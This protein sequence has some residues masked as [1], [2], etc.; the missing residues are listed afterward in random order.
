MIPFGPQLIGQ[1]EKALTAV[2]RKIL[3]PHSL[4]EAQWVTLRLAAQLEPER[5]L[6]EVIRDNNLPDTD[7]L[8]AGLIQR[9]FIVGDHPTDAGREIIASVSGHI[10]E[11]TAPVWATLDSDDVAVTERTL[12]T[13]LQR[14]L[15]VLEVPDKAH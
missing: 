6:S 3:S 5:R 15:S 11:M 7:A 10:A 1:T 12:N 13:V 2:L 8:V 14:V 4:S 9:G